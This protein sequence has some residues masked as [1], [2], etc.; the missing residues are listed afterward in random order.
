MEIKAPHTACSI[1]HAAEYLLS[2]L[3]PYCK[4]NGQFLSYSTQ[5]LMLQVDS[6]T[7][8]RAGHRRCPS[9]TCNGHVFFI[10]QAGS[11]LWTSPAPLLPFDRKE[12]PDDIAE[13]FIEA[14]KCCSVS[15]Y[16][17]TAILLRKT[18]ELLCDH[19]GAEGKTL[20]ARIAIIANRISLSN[21]L[22]EAMQVL[23]LLGN[24][25]VHVTAKEFESIGQTEI[26]VAIEAITKIMEAAFQ[27]KHLVAR[28]KSLR[29]VA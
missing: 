12:I 10:E 24:D 14:L 2:T 26:S 16:T 22:V 11:L 9:H 25:A 5:D 29:N 20:Q 17:A 23:R 13:C 27:H 7:I 18:L 28:L 19:F 4:T 6:A 8:Y 1:A 3:C 21:E 15:C